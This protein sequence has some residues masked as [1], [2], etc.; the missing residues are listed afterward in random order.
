MACNSMFYWLVSDH[1]SSC[2]WRHVRAGCK[3]VNKPMAGDNSAG[4]GSMQPWQAVLRRSHSWLGQ[5]Y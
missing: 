2:H 4:P 3:I 1:V 5:S